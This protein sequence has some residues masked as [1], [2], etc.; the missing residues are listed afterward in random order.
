M[1]LV[2]FLDLRL[3]SDCF[4]CP[5]SERAGTAVLL[6]TV[7]DNELS[8][9][10][11]G[12]AR[13]HA[14][15][16]IQLID[17]MRSRVRFESLDREFLREGS[18]EVTV[19]LEW[20][21]ETHQATAVGH[22]THQGVI[23]AATLA[24]LAALCGADDDVRLELIG[25][26]AVRAFDGWVVITRVHGGFEGD[27]KRL[28]GAAPCERQEDISTA[29]VQAALDATNRMWVGRSAPMP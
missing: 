15:N 12:Q 29:A 13:L 23:Q 27:H 2:I 18:C 6:G 28:L 3:T 10:S 26:K 16:E 14:H 22:E 8:G 1:P 17:T 9:S 20:G 4:P 19:R 25:V 24:T 7:A 11:S 5:L 21:D